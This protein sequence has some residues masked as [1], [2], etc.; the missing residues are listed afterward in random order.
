M[1]TQSN[2]VTVI[3]KFGKRIPP[4]PTTTTISTAVV[5]CTNGNTFITF[6]DLPSMTTVPNDYKNLDW[7][8]SY[9]IVNNHLVSRYDTVFRGNSVKL[10][11]ILGG[12]DDDD[13]DDDDDVHDDD[14][15]VV[16]IDSSDAFQCQLDHLRLHCVH[17][18]ETSVLLSK[19]LHPPFRYS[20]SL[21]PR[22]R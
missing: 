11:T 3:A 9:V 13:D 15:H 14:V 17:R 7:D 16:P 12:I 20:R 5:D 22:H 1:V 4:A 2:I 8:N 10:V 21:A 19:E 6:D 18:Q